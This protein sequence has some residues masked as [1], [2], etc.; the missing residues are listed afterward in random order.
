MGKAIFIGV[1]AFALGVLVRDVAQDYAKPDP[2]CQ[3]AKENAQRF[4]KIIV[5][6]LNRQ[7]IEFDG[8]IVSCRVKHLPEQS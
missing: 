2:V 3:R 7:T 1:M 4:S 8:A 6:L 5:H